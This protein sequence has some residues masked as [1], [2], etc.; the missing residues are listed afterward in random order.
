MFVDFTV[1][2]VPVA[3][4]SLGGGSASVA[5]GGSI[6]PPV[7]VSASDAD[8]VGSALTATR[9]R[10]SGRARALGHGDVGRVHAA[11][12]AD[13]DGHGLGVRVAGHV[14]GRR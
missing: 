2:A 8:T 6:S 13:V 9:V 4:N 14:S 5:Y 3:T 10:A 12:D 1:E 11:G 7:T